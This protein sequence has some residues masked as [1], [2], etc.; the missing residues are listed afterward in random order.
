MGNERNTPELPAM[1]F[2]EEENFVEDNLTNY[3]YR[4][5]GNRFPFA[6]DI[7]KPEKCHSYKSLNTKRKGSKKRRLKGAEYKVYEKQMRW[8][9][10]KNK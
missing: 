5:S 4:M 9:Q 3:E 7:I 1:S 10:N 2:N 8:L 6:S